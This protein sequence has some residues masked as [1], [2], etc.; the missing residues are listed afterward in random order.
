MYFCMVIVEQVQ[1]A[2]IPDTSQSTD[3]SQLHQS[4]LG[5]V[6]QAFMLLV[7]VGFLLSEIMGTLWKDKSVHFL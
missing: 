6:S 4:R 5:L 3:R 1:G 2:F 7:V